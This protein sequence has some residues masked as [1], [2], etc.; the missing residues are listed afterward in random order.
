[1]EE[2]LIRAE[3]LIQPFVFSALDQEVHYLTGLFV[4]IKS[5]LQQR[6]VQPNC[7]M[8][9]L[10]YWSLLHLIAHKLPLVSD[11]SEKKKKN[12]RNTR[13]AGDSK[14]VRHAWA[15]KVWPTGTNSRIEFSV[16][17]ACCVS[18]ASHEMLVLFPLTYFSPTLE[19]TGSL[20]CV[21]FWT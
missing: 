13:V 9:D 21:R 1:M 16:F 18:F 4:H 8:H 17:P 15:P 6:V 7:E 11:T 3:N 19:T 12:G 2:T 20:S 14:E 5:T 10:L